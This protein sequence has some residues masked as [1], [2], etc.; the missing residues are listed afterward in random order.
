MDLKRKRTQCRREFTILADKIEKAIEGKEDTAGQI[1][2][3]LSETASELFEV[4]AAVRDQWCAAEDF[5]E[6]LF[7][8]DQDKSMLYK[9]R[10]HKVKSMCSKTLPRTNSASSLLSA[11][12]SQKP[13]TGKQRLPTLPK[14]ELVKFDGNIKSWL[15]F[16]GQFKKIDEDAHIDACDKFQYLLQSMTVNSAA[17]QLVES[18]PPSAGNYKK[19][20]EA[21]KARFARDDVLIETYVRGL[22]ALTQ[23]KGAANNLTALYDNLQ[24]HL[25]AL[26]TLG[27]TTDKYAI[28]LF[29]MIES[30]LPEEILRAWHRTQPETR[31]LSKLMLFLRQEVESAERIQLARRDYNDVSLVEPMPPTA[32]F[33]TELKTRQGWKEKRFIMCVV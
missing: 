16:W 4:E 11:E 17:R 14:L 23:K 3:L 7:E 9:L 20:V 31:N 30:A 29:P 22:L 18:Y 1:F 12:S 21:L 26:E 13:T 33:V 19:A 27:V 25:Q 28:M 2:E 24:T 8:A 15:Q 5:D 10:W 6:A 32:C